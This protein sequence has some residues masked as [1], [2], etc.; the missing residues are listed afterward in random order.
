MGVGMSYRILVTG[1]AGFI[2]SHVA[3]RCLEQEWEV[4]GIDDLSGGN[5]ENLPEDDNFWFYHGSVTNPHMLEYIW[6]NERQF[7]AVYHLAAYAAECLSPFIANFNYV[8]NLIGT[9]NIVNE[10]IKQGERTGKLPHLVFTSSIA[11]YGHVPIGELPV[12]EE[13]MPNPCDPYGVAKYA[14]ELHIKT[15]CDMWGLPYTIFRPFNVIGPNQNLND[16]YRNVAGIFIKKAME[17]KPFP[18]FGDGTQV[19]AFSDIDIVAPLIAIAPKVERARNETFNIGGEMPFT[20]KELAAVIAAYFDQKENIEWLPARNEVKAVYS[21]PSKLHS[22]FGKPVQM[23]LCESIAKMA[24]WAKTQTLSEP[25][26]FANI[27]IDWKMPPS[28][29]KLSKVFDKEGK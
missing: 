26:P 11:V 13:R 17:G 20:V 15:A 14:C 4:V 5:R 27:E 1:C 6:S 23:E 25:K 7:D 3:R 21:D 9:V 10:C 28:W 12:T 18:I 8:N 19:R 22:V 16:P 2:G 24:E 29:A